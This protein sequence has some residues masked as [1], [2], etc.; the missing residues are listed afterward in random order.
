MF[1]WIDYEKRTRCF[2]DGITDQEV[3]NIHID[4][5]VLTDSVTG[6]KFTLEEMSLSDAKTTAEDLLFTHWSN[7]NRLIIKVLNGI[8]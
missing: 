5:L 1:R 7:T 8:K 2:V 4:K 6:K 3:A